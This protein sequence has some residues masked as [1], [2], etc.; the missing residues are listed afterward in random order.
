METSAIIAALVLLLILAFWIR[1]K[2]LRKNVSEVLGKFRENG[3]IR[4]N[5]A[6]PLADMGLRSKAK[7][8][9][10]LR[11]G[12][13]EALTQL[14]RQ[15]IVCQAERDEESQELKFYLD[16]QKCPNL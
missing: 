8:A 3:A 12:Q 16:E 6:K 13:V 7:Y 5:R 1:I 10:L 4:E 11:D 2:R 15:G 14:M 9:F